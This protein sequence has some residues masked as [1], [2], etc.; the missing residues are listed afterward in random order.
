MSHANRGKEAEKQFRLAC[1]TLAVQQGFTY[2]RVPDARTAMGNSGGEG[3]GDFLAWSRITTP[4]GLADRSYSIEVKEVEHEYRL[5]KANFK[6]DQRA[7]MRMLELAGVVCYVAVLFKP[8]KKWRVTR[9][10]YFDSGTTGS[11][12]MTNLELVEITDWIKVL[13]ANYSK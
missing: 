10:S 12:D 6:N 7:R 3:P 13:H 8:L 2:W 1:E 9:L 4:A 5:P 11:W